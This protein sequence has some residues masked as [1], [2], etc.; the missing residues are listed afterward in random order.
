MLSFVISCYKQCFLYWFVFRVTIG[1]L[2]ASTV[3]RRL[4]NLLSRVTFRLRKNDNLV[5][6]GRRR[7]PA[8][9]F[10]FPSL[11]KIPPLHT[12]WVLCDSITACRQDSP[13]ISF[14]WPRRPRI[15]S[16]DRT[17]SRAADIG[18]AE[19]HLATFNPSMNNNGD[20]CRVWI[21]LWFFCCAEIERKG[22]GGI[23]ACFKLV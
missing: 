11:I 8:V 13:C 5:N 21:V 12:R 18:W 23:R 9:I 3:L 10:S 17:R 16:A 22:E 6:L 14:F 15:I 4:R 7:L 1:C 19:L 20:K 2:T